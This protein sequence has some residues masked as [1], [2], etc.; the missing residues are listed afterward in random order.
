M[1]DTHYLRHAA[2]LEIT[3]VFVYTIDVYTRAYLDIALCV[4]CAYTASITLM[5]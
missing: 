3:A 1:L 5:P 4:L 2:T